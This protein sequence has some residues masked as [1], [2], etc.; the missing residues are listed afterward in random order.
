VPIPDAALL[1]TSVLVRFFHDHDDQLQEHAENL[2]AA[3]LDDQAQL[4]L[5]DLSVYELV[6]VCIRPLGYAGDRARAVVNALFRFR[7]PMLGVER[8]LAANAAELA[9]DLGLSGYDA[10][11]VAAARRLGVPLITADRRLAG[12]AG[13]DVLELVELA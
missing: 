11:F 7:M 9:A 1:D 5:L 4:I 6:N 10:S 3:W 8:G 12:S 13:P 2:R